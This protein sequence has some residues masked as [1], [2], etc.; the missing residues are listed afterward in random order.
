MAKPFPKDPFFQGNFAPIVMECDAPDLP[1]EGEMPKGL[2]GT[3]Y[4]NGPNPHY[5]PRDAGYHWFLGDG[6]VHA[7]AIVEGRVSYRNRWVRTPRW[8]AESAA[9]AALFGSWGSPGT[10]DPAVRSIDGGLANTSML[11]HGGRLMALEEAHLPFALDPVTLASLGYC[12]FGGKLGGRFTAHPKID[13]A[14]G[15]LVFFAYAADGLFSPTMAYGTLDRDGRL[16][17]FETFAAPF[18]S[19]VHDF[20]V[21]KDHVLFPILPLT[22]SMERARSGKPA[23]AWEP[24]KGSHVGIMRRD[25]TVAQMRWFE[26][27]PGYVFHVLN[28]WDE[29][30]RVIADVMRSQAAPLFPLP[31]GSRGDAAK[32]EARLCR[33]T[34]DLAGNSDRFTQTYIDDLPGEFPRIDERFA[35]IKNRH[36]YFAGRQRER[37]FGMTYDC[38]AHLDHATGRRAVYALPAGDMVS[39]PVFVPRAPDAAEGDGW[40]LAVAYRGEEKRSD[41]IVLDATSLGDGPVATAQLSHRVPAG[42][43]GNWRAAA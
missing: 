6:M 41:L 15:E 43:H 5:A 1:I 35:G 31:D 11:W 7:F 23:Y 36:G 9:G 39:E 20:M 37:Q 3:L 30:D 26:G 16:A 17:R 13:P 24:A 28:A 19:M 18:A 10:T 42:F 38:L 27:E 33:W 2:A 25:G 12:D 14:T 4:R 34:F 8:Q 32:A 22:G 21:T 29:D 40:L